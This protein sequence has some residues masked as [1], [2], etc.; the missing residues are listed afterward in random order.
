MVEETKAEEYRLRP[1]LPLESC[2]GSFADHRVRAHEA[3]C[4]RLVSSLPRK[5]SSTL[6]TTSSGEIS[7][8]GLANLA[9]PRSAI[10]YQAATGEIILTKV[11]LE[12]DRVNG[13]TLLI[14]RLAFRTDTEGMKTAKHLHDY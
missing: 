4:Q 11:E 13:S 14:V 5:V 2:L 1:P 3:I 12:T 6:L 10:A 7:A 8:S 9:R